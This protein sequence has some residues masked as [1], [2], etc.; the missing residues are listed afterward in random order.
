MSDKKN[1]E[2]IIEDIGKVIAVSA[3]TGLGSMVSSSMNNRGTSSNS[4]GNS[5]NNNIGGSQSNPNNN[6][7][8]EGNIGGNTSGNNNGNAGGNTGNSNQSTP[9]S[10]NE[11]NGSSNNTSTGD[12]SN[13]EQQVTNENNQQSSQGESQTNTESSESEGEKSSTPQDDI[14]NWM[15]FL[16][17]PIN[18]TD[19]IV[20]HDPELEKNVLGKKLVDNVEM[21]GSNY[22]ST[23][24]DGIYFPIIQ[25]NTH[26]LH[27]SQIISMSIRY[28]GFTPKLKLKISD[29]RRNIQYLG[30]PGLNNRIYVVL[31]CP[32]NGMY[33]KIKLAFYITKRTNETNDTILYECD[34]YHNGL[35][36]VS[37]EQ[38]GDEPLTTFEFC[39]KISKMLKLG[40]AATEDCETIEDK[41]YRQI[42]SQRVG[43][44][45]E[46]Q[47]EIGGLDEESIFDA[48][49]DINGYLV[50][51]NLPW[52][53]NQK[54]KSENLAIDIVGGIESPDPNN[55]D[56]EP[57]TIKRLVT[58][59]AN[60]NNKTIR[61]SQQY[62]FLNTKKSQE[63]TLKSC[64]FLQS[65]CDQNILA[66][67]QIQMIEESIEGT[68]GSNLYE[69]HQ[70][71][72]LGCDMT[73]D[74]DTPYLMQQ[75]IRK[76]Y[77]NKK[78]S[79]QFNVILD[80]VNWGFERGTLITVLMS[81]DDPEKIKAIDL[82]G[83]DNLTNPT[84]SPSEASKTPEDVAET[85]KEPPV[86][87]KKSIPSG[88]LT[89]GGNMIVNPSLTG[90]YYIDGIEYVYEHGEEHLYQY[91]FLIKKDGSSSMLNQ[92]AGPKL[93]KEDNS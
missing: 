28:C 71:E 64:W 14:E 34:Y 57:E 53:F 25:I 93:E 11:N 79:K 26:S 59:M 52:V 62:D 32:V 23:K 45:I 55:P 63:G 84:I 16:E 47:I 37:C 89:N 69:F 73:E 40:F 30:G 7:N 35:M 92:Y 51:V 88:D 65:P 21:P 3:V 31:T 33:K 17:E 36:A 42:Y 82:Y 81:E 76:M 67:E 20:I 85:F 90:I 5:L 1:W 41:R 9:P 86:A 49:I 6:S 83:E 77:L 12:S 18:V 19:P 54:I 29:P 2:K 10:N 24:V 13:Q 58:N 87:N 72:F 80:H 39:E 91:L 56:P 50:L 66:C 60:I 44:F 48:W 75:S 74:G 46:Q 38:I 70:T 78:R 4:F 15:T 61:F 8:T 68:I 27:P 22:E 43:D